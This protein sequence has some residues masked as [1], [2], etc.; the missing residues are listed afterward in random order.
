MIYDKRRRA[1]GFKPESSSSFILIH[2][3]TVLLYKS[4]ASTLSLHSAYLKQS[5]LASL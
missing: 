1:F 2:N 3:R 4:S 5:H